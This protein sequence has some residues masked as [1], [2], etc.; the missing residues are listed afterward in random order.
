MFGFG[1]DTLF[2]PNFF[3]EI[4]GVLLTYESW[5]TGAW[6]PDCHFLVDAMCFAPTTTT[7]FL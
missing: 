7:W 5:G 6:S 1:T 3:L 2:V 4:F